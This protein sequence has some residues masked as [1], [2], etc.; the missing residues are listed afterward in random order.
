MK[1]Q[2][3]PRRDP[4]AARAQANFALICSLCVFIILV[5]TLL[6]FSAGTL[7]MQY[8]GLSEYV[9]NTSALPFIFCAIASFAIGF[10]ITPLIL[11]V[12]MGPVNRL[13]SSM[14]R[15]ASGHFD[16]RVDLGQSTLGRE[17]T[18]SF[19]TLASELQNTELL[20]TDFINNLSHEFKTP[21]V[22]IRGFARILQ[23]DEA[24]RDLAPEQRAA[25][26][27]AIVDESSR[28]ASMATGIL[29][30]S[31]VENQQILTDVAEFNL[32]EQLRRCILLREKDWARKELEISADFSEF[33]IS[34]NEEL[35][36]QVWVNLLDNAIKFTP[37]GG[38]ITVRIY[39]RAELLRARSTLQVDVINTGSPLSEE[40]QR[41][42]FDRFWQADPSHAAA[43]TGVGLSIVRRIAELHGGSV[44][45]ES[46]P[47]ETCFSVSLPNGA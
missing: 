13:I 9:D 6:L 29:H 7:I 47:E 32:S 26:L 31:K 15:L 44:S 27:D 18:D 46:N 43:G 19:N 24:A 45:V 4:R 8:S 25:Y 17:L 34:A 2:P 33:T 23:R 22:S 14:R 35:L 38:R 11:R 40:Q 10:S 3:S 30:L 21:I 16:E 41:R 12:P 39:A 28:L 36:R 42:V 1:K 20:R 5:I 37:P